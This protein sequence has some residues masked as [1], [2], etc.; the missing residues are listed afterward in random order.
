MIGI[1]TSRNNSTII[2]HIYNAYAIFLEYHDVAVDNDRSSPF[3]TVSV[4]GMGV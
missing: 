1:V 3:K 2:K 4:S